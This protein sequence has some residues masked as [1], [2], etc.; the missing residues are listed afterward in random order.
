M[1]TLLIGIFLLTTGSAMACSC[2]NTEYRLIRSLSEMQGINREA[3]VI[4]DF[5]ETLNVVYALPNAIR[6]G[7]SRDPMTECVL[8][9]SMKGIKVKAH[10][11]YEK[12]GQ[13]CSAILIKPARVEHRIKLKEIVCN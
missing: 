3:V 7:L 10:V 1:K 12:D 2:V 6:A 9:C 11:Q 8:S 4:N 5:K 13:L